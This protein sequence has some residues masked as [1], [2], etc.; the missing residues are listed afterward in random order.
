MHRS[1]SAR[2]IYVLAIFEKEGSIESTFSIYLWGQAQTLAGGLVGGH[3]L[4]GEQGEGH[5]VLDASLQ[6]SDSC[7]VVVRV[8]AEQLVGVRIVTDA[9]VAVERKGRLNKGPRELGGGHKNHFA[10]ILK[11]LEEGVG[12]RDGYHI[13]GAA[14]R[15]LCD[16]D[17]LSRRNRHIYAQN[18][19]ALK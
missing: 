18:K 16:G 15:V 14:G 6:M 10:C 2:S 5:R 9:H 17:Q 12:G 3:A 11:V 1:L 7:H 8:T 19:R 13:P 4:G